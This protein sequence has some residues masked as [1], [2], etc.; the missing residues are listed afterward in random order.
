MMMTKA[1]FVFNI[2]EIGLRQTGHAILIK[3]VRRLRTNID[4]WFFD[5]THLINVSVGIAA[6]VQKR[7]AV[8]GGTFKRF[9][10]NILNLHAI[11]AK[12]TCSTELKAFPKKLVSRALKTFWLIAILRVS[13]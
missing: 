3:D 7:V 9:Q 12:D 2:V 5:L 6:Q 8:F 10:N 1:T 13:H 11:S 4:W